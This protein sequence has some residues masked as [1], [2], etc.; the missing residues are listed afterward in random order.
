MECETREVRIQ[1]AKKKL[2][3]LWGLIIVQIW[4]WPMWFQYI[5]TFHI[6]VS[7][8]MTM[9]MVAMYNIIKIIDETGK[10]D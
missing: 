6:V 8:F 10:L 1:K 5:S 9:M 4:L 7:S 2:Y 3:L